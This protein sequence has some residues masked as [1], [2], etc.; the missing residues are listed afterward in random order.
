MIAE[1]TRFDPLDYMASEAINT[2]CTNLSFTGKDKK[3]I[4]ITS[5]QASEGKTFLSLNMMR[6]LTQLGKRVVLVDADLRRSMMKT[7][8]GIRYPY[9]AYGLAHYLAGMC[10]QEQIIY[11]TNITNAYIIPVG[12]TVTN[13]LALLNTPLLG[14]M[15]KQLATNVDYVLV[16]APPIG[17]IIDPAEIAKSCDG[18][19]I[20]VTYNSVSRRELAEVKQQI[21]MAGCEVLGAVLNNVDPNA[22]GGKK[23]YYYKQQ[24]KALEDRQDHNVKTTRSARKTQL[25]K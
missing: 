20:V 6:T 16:D 1:F 12:R 5:C 21:E 8:F 19:L 3:I 18:A 25:L 14:R 22:L 23:Y 17:A 13:S 2:L 24:Y 15:L 9:E 4:M 11:E 7:Q 10:T